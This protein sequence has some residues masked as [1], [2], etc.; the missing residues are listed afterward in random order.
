MGFNDQ[1]GRS[2]RITVKCRCGNE[3]DT[4][5]TEKPTIVNCG[6]CGKM[7][8]VSIPKTAPIKSPKG[9]R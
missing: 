9:K 4:R 1:G 5:A 2:E 6:T 7:H 3:I 8:T